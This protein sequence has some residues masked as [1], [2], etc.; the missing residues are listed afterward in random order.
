MPKAARASAC[1]ALGLA[2]FAVAAATGAADPT[3]LAMNAA[4]TSLGLI[5]WALAGATLS[6]KPF[7]RRLG[8]VPS[9]LSPAVIAGLV[10]GMLALSQLAEWLIALAGYQ[11]V[12]NL[13]EFR[14]VLRQARGPSLGVALV[15][16]ALLPG[17]AEEVALRGFVQRGL[18][19]RIGGAAAVGLTSLLFALLHGEL[20][21][22][23]GALLLGLYLGTIVA[24]C[25]SI[26]PAVVCHVANNAM[27]TL[28]SALSLQWLGVLLALAGL[29]LGP[30]AL[31]RTVLRARAA[32]PPLGASPEPAPPAAPP[33]GAPDAR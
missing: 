28:G 6:G 17:V 13:P 1:F 3:A 12:G 30:W 20:V 22:G 27:A 7:A 10:L 18:H 23:A 29:A 16:V 33:P 4:A 2:A 19:P 9:H 11:D 31:W 32:H 24:L 15:G 8:W 25:G 14:R 26:R 5:A 21:H